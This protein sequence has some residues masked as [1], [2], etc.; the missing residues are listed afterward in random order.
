MRAF[1][2]TTLLIACM[3]LPCLGQASPSTP[4]VAEPDDFALQGRLVGSY[5][6]DSLDIR[7][8]VD[9]ARFWAQ[10]PWG[11]TEWLGGIALGIAADAGAGWDISQR[12]RFLLVNRGVVKPDTLTLRDMDFVVSRARIGD[13][14]GHWLVFA[15][16]DGGL[17]GRTDVPPVGFT[18][19][20]TPRDLL[21]RVHVPVARRP[22]K[23]KP[24]L[25]VPVRRLDCQAPPAIAGLRGTVHLTFV[26]SA[27]GEAEPTSIAPVGDADSTLVRAAARVVQGCH[28][29]PE[30]IDGHPVRSE[31]SM[32]VVF[33]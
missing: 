30:L 29:A 2:V 33:Q 6:V 13:L 28:F 25:D 17:E 3:A 9:S 20:H 11:G 12:S 21:E 31:T 22:P 15:L 7:V 27:R 23:L 14:S 18:Y 8:H 1:R 26:V 4:F 19:A 16:A 24:N 5:S 10:P 32:P